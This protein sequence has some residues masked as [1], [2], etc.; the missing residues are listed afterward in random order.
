METAS[1][2]KAYE[3]TVNAM[4]ALSAVKAKLGNIHY[5]L[6]QVDDT[7]F[8]LDNLGRYC[9]PSDDAHEVVFERLHAAKELAELANRTDE[10]QL[11]LDQ[12]TEAYFAIERAYK[13]L[14]A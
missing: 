14:K 13:T 5:H 9:T 8:V 10:R 3:E 6:K 4:V 12:L 2:K 11:I 1:T 7:Q